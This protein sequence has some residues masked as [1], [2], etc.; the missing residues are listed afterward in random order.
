[1]LSLV[2][3]GAGESGRFAMG[4]DGAILDGAEDNP[5]EGENPSLPATFR[6]EE[7]IVFLNHCTHNG[8]AVNY[9]DKP[10]RAMIATLENTG[11]KYGVT[12]GTTD[13]THYALVIPD[14]ATTA[15][16]NCGDDLVFIIELVYKNGSKLGATLNGDWAANGATVDIPATSIGYYHIKL[17]KADDS[18]F[19]DNYDYTGISWTFN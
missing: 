1:V 15:T 19:A 5:P 9:Y 4:P 6:I 13:T 16:V 7:P 17:K 14:G 12:T 8:G 11:A 2:R 18:I 3:V 10:T